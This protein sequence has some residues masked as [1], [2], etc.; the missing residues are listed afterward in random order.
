M[1]TSPSPPAATCPH[2]TPLP[3][4]TTSLHLATLPPGLWSLS[5]LPAVM[6]S[7]DTV[8]TALSSGPFPAAVKLT[9]TAVTLNRN[10]KLLLI[11][12]PHQLP[13]LPLHPLFL[14]TLQYNS[15]KEWFPFAIS[16]SSPPL[17][18]ES[19]SVHQHSIQTVSANNPSQS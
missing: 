9:V 4:T 11:S 15:W 10:K 19:T 12:L 17:A 3:I 13:P 16:S 6:P 18:L 7:P 1:A 8:K 5:L 2:S 14:S